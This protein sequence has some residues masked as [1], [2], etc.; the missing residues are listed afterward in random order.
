MSQKITRF[1]ENCLPNSG[2]VVPPK[3]V[4]YFLFRRNINDTNKWGFWPVDV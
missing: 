2:T 4:P 3:L 1:P